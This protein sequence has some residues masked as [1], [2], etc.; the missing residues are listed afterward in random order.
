MPQNILE[1]IPI[2]KKYIYWGEKWGYQKAFDFLENDPDFQSLYYQSCFWKG[3]TYESVECLLNLAK[4]GNPV[5][6]S[7]KHSFIFGWK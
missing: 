3:R 6:I 4:N 2:K 5:M 7:D 1:G